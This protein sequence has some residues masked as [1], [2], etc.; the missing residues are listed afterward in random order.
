MI[1]LK[2]QC[3]KLAAVSVFLILVHTLI[4]NLWD[5]SDPTAASQWGQNNIRTEKYLF[6]ATSDDCVLLGS[7]MSAG[8][9]FKSLET[10]FKK[11]GDAPRLV[12]LA[13]AGGS[14]MT[15]M[16]I[17][18]MA[19]FAP[20]CVL[21][22]ANLAYKLEDEK[23]IDKYQNSLW[24]SLN[25]YIKNFRH[26][27][28]PLNMLLTLLR[29]IRDSNQVIASAPKSVI[30]SEAAS[31]SGVEKPIDPV[32]LQS[33]QARLE[34]LEQIEDEFIEIGAK[35]MFELAAQIEAKGTKVIFFEMPGEELVRSSHYYKV[36]QAQFEDTQSSATPRTL[37]RLNIKSVGTRDGIHLDEHSLTLVPEK[38]L[39]LI[40][41]NK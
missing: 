25:R 5:R 12:N 37:H 2:Q 39:T 32:R 30:A 27:N 28:Q 22:E 24:F 17:V 6:G 34:G 10:S 36:V 9:D 41:S 19:D 23:H 13:L 38:L 20:A 21:V 7:S 11:T 26:E 33:I 4:I 15:G 3:A 29:Q 35:H 14:S 40:F 16:Q 1:S 18:L 31:D 8:V